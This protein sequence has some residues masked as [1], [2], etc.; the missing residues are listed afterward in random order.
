[1]ALGLPPKPKMIADTN[2]DFPVPLGPMIK[3]KDFP[4]NRVTSL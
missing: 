3:F 4:G 1:M 2:V